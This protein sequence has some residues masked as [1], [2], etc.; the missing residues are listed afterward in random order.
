MLPQDAAFQAGI[1]VI[2]QLVMFA[3]LYGYAPAEARERAQRA[4]DIVGLGEVSRRN[5]RVLSHGMRKRVALCQAFLGDPEVVF[6]D[7][8]TSGLDPENARKMRDLVR[9]MRE[10]QTVVLSS[11]NLAEVQELC[12]HAAI[13]HRGRLE[14]CQSMEELTAANY[15]IRVKLGQP[16]PE[17]AERDLRALPQVRSLERTSDVEFNLELALE[18]ASQKEAALRAVHD[19]LVARHGLVPRSLYEGASLEARFLQITGGTFDGSGAT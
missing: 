9:Q 4:L 10:Q 17:A 19:V 14:V 1:P 11:H 7:E 15:L 5:A 18:E 2:D 16:L 6:L 13:L 12:D 3:R 8:P